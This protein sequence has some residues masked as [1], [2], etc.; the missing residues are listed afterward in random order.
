MSWERLSLLSSICFDGVKPQTGDNKIPEITSVEW[1]DLV[2]FAIESHLA[3]LLHQAVTNTDHGIPKKAFLILENARNQVLARNIRLQQSFKWML[4]ELNLKGIP[5]V[6][7]KGIYSSEKHYRDISL[8]HLSDIDILV[9]KENAEALLTLVKASGWKV[10]SAIFHS[11]LVE[12]ELEKAHPY[13]FVKDGIMIELHTHLYDRKHGARLS[14]AE[15]WSHAQEEVFLGGVIHQFEPEMLLQHWCLHL[16]K[17]IAVFDVKMASFWDIKLL[18]DDAKDFRWD[19][20]RQLCKVYDCESAAY[21]VLH[22]CRTYWHM[23]IPN[24]VCAKKESLEKKFLW[25]L[26]NNSNKDFKH[27]EKRLLFN[28][29]K[30]GK[31]K[32]PKEKVLFVFRFLF[33]KKEFMM[34]RYGTN[35]SISVFPLYFLRPILLALKLTR[36]VYTKLIG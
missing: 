30:L 14:E 13:T 22:L 33:P 18:L 5:V 26:E 8:R 32:S 28:L 29:N 15:L 19:R 36:A 3:P 16:E 6:P 35:S 4:H 17:H 12:R 27:E 34:D 25:C 1:E 10:E 2:Q 7:L 31:L 9:K 24:N 21:S 11:D 20:F 23:Q